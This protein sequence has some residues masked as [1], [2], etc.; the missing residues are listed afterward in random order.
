MSKKKVDGEEDW[1][2]GAERQKK[3]ESQRP[4]AIYLLQR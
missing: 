1:R 4:T 2:E 3:R